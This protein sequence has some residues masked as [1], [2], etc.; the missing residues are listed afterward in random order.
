MRVRKAVRMKLFPGQQEEYRRRHSEI[1]PELRDLLKSAGV[2]DYSIFLDEETLALI[3]VLTITNEEAM[4]KLPSHP[5]M[6]KWWTYMKD[7]M[8]T[9]PDESPVGI[10]LEEVFYLK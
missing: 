10:P 8:D 3:G 6:K 7:I 9:N 2:E 1:W 5:V 4:D